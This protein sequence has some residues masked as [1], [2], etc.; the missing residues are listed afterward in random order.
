M[1]VA[2]GWIILMV[3]EHT[4]RRSP[5]AGEHRG[6]GA[7]EI[8]LTWARKILTWLGWTLTLAWKILTLTKKMSVDACCCLEDGG[9]RHAYA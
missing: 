6:V 5:V 3:R 2:G 8:I 1:S 4:R 9:W 7:C